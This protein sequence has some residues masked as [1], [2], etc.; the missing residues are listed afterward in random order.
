MKRGILVLAALTL[1]L[2][3]AGYYVASPEPDGLEAVAERG[4]FARR[5]STMGIAPM[6]GYAVPF[7][8]SQA[9]RNMAAGLIGA[10]VCFFAAFAIGRLTAHKGKALAPGPTRPLE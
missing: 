6:A 2:C 10:A 8:R 7:F 9:G 3:T 1:M 5:G 4:N